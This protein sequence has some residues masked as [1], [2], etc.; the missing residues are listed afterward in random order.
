MATKVEPTCPNCG[1]KE[2]EYTDRVEGPGDSWIV[3][4]CQEC[5]KI[6]ADYELE[7][8]ESEVNHGS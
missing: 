6:M 2:F 5:G 1:G 7:E 3:L 8:N 4:K